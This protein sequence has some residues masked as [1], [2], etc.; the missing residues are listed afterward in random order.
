MI[1][2][3]KI[4]NLNDLIAALF[5]DAFWQIAYYERELE[6]QRRQREIVKEL[7]EKLKAADPTFEIDKDA[8]DGQGLEY[9]DSLTEFVSYLWGSAF[10]RHHE[11]Q[12]V[13][14]HR[15]LA[16]AKQL[17]IALDLEVDIEAIAAN[18][19]GHSR[20]T[21]CRSPDEKTINVIKAS[22]PSLTSWCFIPSGMRTTEPA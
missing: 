12:S 7:V 13:L 4:E 21:V 20:K 5:G 11:E 10:E 3:E 6:W 1:S 2:W 22:A 19:A 18:H 15:E 9:T 16:I 17:M 14:A 8:Y